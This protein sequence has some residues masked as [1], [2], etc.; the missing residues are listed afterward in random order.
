MAFFHRA[1]AYYVVG[2][3]HAHPSTIPVFPGFYA[4]AV[5]AGIEVTV[6]NQ[7]VRAT[8]GITPVVVRPQAFDS[9]IT[10]CYI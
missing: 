5:V 10:D 3:G 8:F 2:R 9:H 1:V 7:N 4:D 6:L